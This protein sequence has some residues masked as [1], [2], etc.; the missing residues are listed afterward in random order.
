ML[1]M[2]AGL[3][4]FV[5]VDFI[6]LAHS[7]VPPAEVEA[8]QQV[9]KLMGATNWRLNGNSC[10]LEA[11]SQVSKPH[12]EADATVRCD[13]DCNDNSTDC[14]VV[15][16]VHKYYSLGG[17]LPPELVKLPYLQI[18][19]FAFNYLQGTIP[20]ELGSTKMQ[21]ISLLGNRFSG[22]IPGELGN[23]TTLTYLYVL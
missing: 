19:D 1:V 16:I 22:Q 2:K 4:L 20:S 7:V 6:R 23:I 21:S 11:I 13:I 14:H 18:I 5:L 12:P 3:M 10:Q 8:F 9:M 15:S 17:V